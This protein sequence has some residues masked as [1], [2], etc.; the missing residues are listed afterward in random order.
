[1]NG[2]SRVYTLNPVS[3]NTSLA[4]REEFVICHSRTPTPTECNVLWGGLNFNGNDA[5]ELQRNG[6]PIDTIG[7]RNGTGAESGGWTVSG[8]PSATRYHILTRHPGVVSGNLN[9]TQSSA[10]EWLVQSIDD[11]DTLSPSPSSAQSSARQ[12]C[13]AMGDQLGSLSLDACSSGDRSMRSRLVIGTYNT[14]FLFDGVDDRISVWS[15]AS[16][17]YAHLRNIADVIR[18]NRPDIL[19]LA[20][21][22]DRQILVNLTEEISDPDYRVYF[23]QGRDTFTGQDVGLIS[24]IPTGG[25]DISRTDCRAEYPVSGSQCGGSGTGSTG[26]S[27]NFVALFDSC[28]FGRKFAMIG[29][30]LISR[31]TDS[32]RCNQR[33]AQAQVIQDV[34][35]RLIAANFEVIVLGDLNDFS[36]VIP[37]IAGSVPTSRV[38]SMFRDPDNDGVDELRSVLDLLPRR[39]RYTDWYDRNEDGV[40]DGTSKLSTLDH[41][42]MTDDLYRMV[43]RVWIDHDYDPAVV[44]DHFPLF[45]EFR[46][47]RARF[48]RAAVAAEVHDLGNALTVSLEQLQNTP[49]REEGISKEVENRIRLRCSEIVCGVLSL[50]AV[51]RTVTCTA[52]IY[53]HRY[54]CQRSVAAFD[55]KYIALGVMYLALKTEETNISEDELIPVFCRFL[56]RAYLS[57]EK[58]SVEIEWKLR[59]CTEFDLWWDWLVCIELDILIA[60]GFKLHVPRPHKLMFTY[61]QKLEM[62]DFMQEAW[63]AL[64][65]SYSTT[66]CVQF[67]AEDQACGAIFYTARKHG[68]GL[69]ESGRYSWWELFGASEDALYAYAILLHELYTYQEDDFDFTLD[70]D[71]TYRN[72]RADGLKKPHPQLLNRVPDPVQRNQ[73]PQETHNVVNRL[74]AV[75]NSDSRE[76]RSPR[77][78][79]SRRREDRGREDRRRDKRH[80]D[81]HRRHERRRSRDKRHRRSPERRRTPLLLAVVVTTKAKLIDPKKHFG[82]RKF[83]K[84]QRSPKFPLLTKLKNAVMPSKPSASV[85]TTLDETIVVEVEEDEILDTEAKIKASGVRVAPVR[86]PAPLP[87][88]TAQSVPSPNRDCIDIAPDTLYTCAEQKAFGKCDAEFMVSGN[89]CAKT[90]GRSPCTSIGEKLSECTD[91]PPGPNFTCAQQKEFGKCFDEFMLRGNYCAK[92]CGRAPCPPVDDDFCPTIAEGVEGSPLLSVLDLALEVTDLKYAFDDPELRVTVFAPSNTAFES[93]LNDLDVT[94][95]ALL[96]FPDVIEKILAVHVLSAPLLSDELLGGGK[97]K[98]MSEETSEVLVLNEGGEVYVMAP[99]GVPAKVISSDLDACGSI[100]HVIDYVLLPDKEVLESL[101]L[102]DSVISAYESRAR[103]TRE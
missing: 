94:A 36:D 4:S 55:Y 73:S 103:Q 68:V 83:S 76:R 2:G 59:R 49:S 5:I 41:I 20:E 39:L 79:S 14:Y 54:Y 33:E 13:W 96:D 80:E 10:A 25:G 42:L 67:K 48:N 88:P 24:Q 99:Y 61:M 46:P 18:R 91:V 31:P 64:N 30:H 90:C 6:V 12:S 52:Q 43:S 75:Q 81:H 62:Q 58:A 19:Q 89:F 66:C 65:D 15:N 38:L 74:P 35:Q 92:T 97:F 11:D 77:E 50:C 37:D 53:L 23:V 29:L 3:E 44:S 102:P 87:K 82:D 47:R 16:S 71:I 1:M 26:V 63:T 57:D 27:K 22:E 93:L 70:L 72:E 45:V 51:D 84:L 86:N 40:I 56:R 60:F 9:W 85:E 95:D 34:M 78:R 8:V 7:W 32:R 101:S 100:V 28:L 21:V 98:T 17:A 69:P